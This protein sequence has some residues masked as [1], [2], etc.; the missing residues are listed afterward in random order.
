[1]LQYTKHT[2]NT[3]P[4]IFITPANYKLNKPQQKP[5][6]INQTIRH[7]KILSTFILQLK[8]QPA[9]ISELSNLKFNIH[10]FWNHT[11]RRLSFIGRHLTTTPNN[12]YN[13]Y[14]LYLNGKH[15]MHS[16]SRP[17]LIY[18]PHPIQ[19]MQTYPMLD[20]EHCF[21]V[22]RKVVKTSLSQ[23]KYQFTFDARFDKSSVECVFMKVHPNI[24]I[25]PTTAQST[26][27]W[28]KNDYITVSSKYK[29]NTYTVILVD[30]FIVDG[31][32]ITHLPYTERLKRLQVF[33]C[34]IIK[35]YTPKTCCVSPF[36]P[37]TGI[38]Y[39]SD[40]HMV[41][42][43]IH[44]T[45]ITNKHVYNCNTD[46]IETKKTTDATLA[47]F[48][49]SLYGSYF[50]YGYVYLINGPYLYICEFNK[51]EMRFEHSFVFIQ[52][53]NLFMFKSKREYTEVYNAKRKPT[54]LQ[55]V[56]LYFNHEDRCVSVHHKF[57]Y[58]VI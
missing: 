35:P 58:C 41:G 13:Q 34:N 8:Q 53:T 43:P 21:I 7:L 3:K 40:L 18:S 33:N 32:I 36:C 38:I 17:K 39:K 54:G 48:S 19:N 22:N 51:N 10:V 50:K 45:E 26:I 44:Y 49:P 42:D 47:E 11:I 23:I 31:E 27:C 30:G 28:D 5:I 20:G 12:I 55:L 57:S 14:L 24:Y 56:K 25:K 1:M 2:D 29:S 4:Q 37:V 15:Q 9:I 6:L 46:T 16:L 52:R